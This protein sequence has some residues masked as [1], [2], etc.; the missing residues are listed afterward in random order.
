MIFF[1]HVLFTLWVCI[2]IYV[3]TRPLNVNVIWVLIF[4]FG[5]LCMQLIDIDHYGGDLTQLAKAGMVTGEREYYM[6][7]AYSFKQG[8]L[9]NKALL[10]GVTSLTLGALTGWW[11]HFIKDGLI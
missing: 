8:I 10:F 4:T 9:H 6:Y 1:K 2:L 7:Y 5:A 3:V 11:L